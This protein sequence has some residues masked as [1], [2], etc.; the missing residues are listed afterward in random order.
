MSGPSAH[1]Q[2]LIT[3]I[4]L[5]TGHLSVLGSSTIIASIWRGRSEKL[6]KPQHRLLLGLSIVDICYSLAKAWTFLLSPAGYPFSVPG[7]QGNM[8]TCRMQGFFIQI[9]HIGGAYNAALSLYFYLTICRGMKRATFARRIEPL[10][11]TVFPLL[12]VG[13]GIA[14]VVTRLYNPIGFGPCF[15]GPYPPG[16]GPETFECQLHGDDFV[17]LYE[18]YA[19]MWVQL[20]MVVIFVTNIAIWW[21]IFTQERA[22]VKYTKHIAKQDDAMRKKQYRHSKRVAVQSTLYIGAYLLSWLGPTVYHL[23]SWTTGYQAFW[24]LMVLVILTPLQGFFNAFI[25][26]R[27]SYLR[28]REAKPNLSRWVAV[29]HSFF[30]PTIDEANNAGSVL[31]SEMMNRN[32]SWWNPGRRVSK[33][34]GSRFSSTQS[35]NSRSK[36]SSYNAHSTTSQKAS[37]AIVSEEEKTEEVPVGVGVTDGEQKM[38]SEEEHGD[39]V[40]DNV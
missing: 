14:G 29:K 1:Q 22:M 3:Y 7:A 26:A 16:C 8:A 4:P 30:P 36:F 31:E 9:A 12:N 40:R 15:I 23:L 27:P 37:L 2:K 24:S 39:A 18:I 13:F 33:F 28:M 35:L 34:V 38:K 11:H 32:G 21:K 6:Q 25:Y 5:L 19:Q 10:V 20:Y 17:I